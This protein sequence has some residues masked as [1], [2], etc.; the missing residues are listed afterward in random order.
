MAYFQKC[1]YF[2]R[3]RWHS[4]LMD[5]III[6]RF[7]FLA[8]ALEG[9]G[10]FMPQV[11]YAQ[12]D[13]LQR[14]SKVS[15]DCAIVPHPRESPDKY[16][17]RV[18]CA[19]YENH[20]RSACE[21]FAAYLARKSPSRQGI[22]NPFVGYFLN[23]ADGMGNALD[24][25]M[26]RIAIDTKARGSMLVLL[27]L[28]PEQTAISL[29]EMMSGQQRS[30]PYLVPIKPET[31]AGYKL[32][33]RG[34]F[35]LVDIKAKHTAEDG[36]EL[37][38]V[39]RWT[40]TNWEV[41]NGKELL[42][43]GEHPFGV[44]PVLAITENGASFPQVGK[45]AQ[46]ADLSRRLYN[47]SAELVD[48][49]RGQTFSVLALQ[50]PKDV[51]DPAQSASESVAQIGVHSLLIHQGNTPA[52]ISP[53][54]EPAQVYMAERAAIQSSID[55]IGMETATQAGQQQESGL[56][57]KMRF[58]ALNADLAGFARLL[59]GLEARIWH[60]FHYALGLENRVLAQYPT[61]YNLTDTA[62]EL[63]ILALMQATGHPEPVQREKRRAII[64]SEFDRADPDTLATLLASV[65][66][67]EQEQAAL[68]EF[69]A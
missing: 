19:V 16:A 3:L 65:D 67:Q 4:G 5:S 59:Q 52:F 34:Q 43:Q 14:P 44:C 64:L 24:V 2:R 11:Q 61:D 23:D 49:L 18:D 20:L 31:L 26:H 1:A 50:I 48:M 57:R 46:I 17:A 54:S 37:D 30:V 53:S 36:K 55:R 33:E 39:R 6:N 15:G 58:E 25:V 66:E 32:D 12:S 29:A 13:G 8:Q 68:P 22:E 40:A 51:H 35:E 69:A 62:A 42:A 27:D 38:V 21:R 10:Q 41:W 45:Y 63:D 60:L 56:A 28:P 9:L 47:S 7:N